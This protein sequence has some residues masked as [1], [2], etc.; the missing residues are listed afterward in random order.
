L[1]S[2]GTSEDIRVRYAQQAGG[3]VCTTGWDDGTAAYEIQI[4][5][6]GNFGTAPY[7]SFDTNAFL[8]YGT[9]TAAITID[10]A[11]ST[12]IL[13]LQA[14]TN[15]DSRIH[16]R[17]D[18]STNAVA[19]WDAGLSIF[20]IHTSSSFTTL[21]AGDFSISSTG[22]IYMGNLRSVSNTNYLRHNTGTGEVT[23]YS[24]D[25]RLKK[26]IRDFDVDA[27]D[28]LSQFK[29]RTFEWIAEDDD[30]VSN[31]WIAQEA[32]DY[33]PLMF[34]IVEKT[35]LHSQSE[36]EILPYYHKAIIQ[37]KERIEQLESQLAEK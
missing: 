2:E 1:R 27:L 32:V 37:L 22:Y 8:M 15:Q 4:G 29:P 5:S 14:A 7:Y 13:Y 24:S 33:I 12:A 30:K 36:A 11:T 26:N 9:S 6:G 34:P 25:R 28:A 20:Q 23:Y 21:A 16:F 18:A 3:I 17:Y 19:G 10:A 31:G 35:G